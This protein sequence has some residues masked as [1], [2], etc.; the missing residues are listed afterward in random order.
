MSLRRTFRFVA[1]LSPSLLFTLVFLSPYYSARLSMMLHGRPFAHVVPKERLDVFKFV[2]T[3]S[4]ACRAIVFSKEKAVGW[5][6]QPSGGFP[7]YVSF[8]DKPNFRDS[9]AY[10]PWFGLPLIIA[11][12]LRWW[13][14]PVQVVTLLL[15]LRQREREFQHPRP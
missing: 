8:S 11:W 3:D 7:S 12:A 5:I 4:F 2:S 9:V 13:L 10:H 15:W 6:C 1:L 14:L